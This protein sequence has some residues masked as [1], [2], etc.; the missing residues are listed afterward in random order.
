MLDDDY[1]WIGH[2]STC[3]ADYTKKG[4]T[5]K[6]V[7]NVPPKSASQLKASI[8]Q[9]PTSITIDASSY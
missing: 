3:M 1:P 8:S 9:A 2:E 4:A 5:V 6:S 7:K